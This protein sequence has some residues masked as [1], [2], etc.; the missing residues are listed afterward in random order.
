MKVLIDSSTLIAL[1][2]IGELDFLNIY[3]DKIYITEEIR[4]EVTEKDRPENLVISKNVGDWIKIIEKPD[5]DHYSGLKGLDEGEKTLLN[6]AKENDDVMLLLDEN[7]ARAVAKA[8]GFDFTGTLGLIVFLY[9]KNK[10]SK[11]RANKIVK[12]L[13]HSDFRMTVDLYDWVLGKL[14]DQNG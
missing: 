14:S 1:A 6:Y 4:D 2:K 8:E 9:E 12:K 3:N 5:G 7:E 13:A 10:L 11:K